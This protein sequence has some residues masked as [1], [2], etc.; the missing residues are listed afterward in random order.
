ML[1]R[2]NRVIAVVRRW[3]GEAVKM[4]WKFVLYEGI[5]SKPLAIPFA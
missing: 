3:N 5:T 1:A 4:E 2:A